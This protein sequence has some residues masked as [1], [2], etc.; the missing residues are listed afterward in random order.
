MTLL[1]FSRI[2]LLFLKRIH[3][4][5]LLLSFLKGLLLMTVFQQL[6]EILILGQSIDHAIGISGNPQHYCTESED[7]NCILRPSLEA[8]DLQNQDM[9]V[10]LLKEPNHL[11]NLFQKRF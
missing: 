7:K 6:Q 10:L 1:P 11:S 8:L 9:V 2:L 3:P 5:S 4:P